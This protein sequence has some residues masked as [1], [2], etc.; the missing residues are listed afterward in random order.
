MKNSILKRSIIVISILLLI[1]CAF[2]CVYAADENPS[3]VTM[4]TLSK[5]GIV[6]H[7]PSNWGYSEST[8]NYSFMALSKLSSIDSFGVGQFH[9]KRVVQSVYGRT[10]AIC[11]CGQS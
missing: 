11:R 3:E 1:I 5:N 7:Y 2:S 6:V 8:S 4:E 9:G 10:N